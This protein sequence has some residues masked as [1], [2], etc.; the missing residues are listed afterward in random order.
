MAVTAQEVALVEFR[1]NRRPKGPVLGLANTE[2]LPCGVS[3]V[4]V[5][6][7]QATVVPA[8]DTGTPFVLHTL[9][10]ESSQPFSLICLV[11]DL[12]VGKAFVCPLPTF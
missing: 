2:I 6:G 9:L 8:P 12:A 11:A 4:E 1:L 3:V 5:Q 10:L 7:S